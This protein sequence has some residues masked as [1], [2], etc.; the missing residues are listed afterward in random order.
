MFGPVVLGARLPASLDPNPRGG[1][2]GNPVPD[3]EPRGGTMSRIANV[4]PRPIL[5]A[6]LFLLPTACTT[7]QAVPAS[8]AAVI[9]EQRP[10][11]V[12]LTLGT[13]E[14]RSLL[15]PTVEGD[16]IFGEGEF[17]RVGV[18]I[19]DVES[20]EVQRFSTGRTI[21]SGAV[22]VLLYLAFKAFFDSDQFG[23]GTG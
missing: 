18:P 1:Q 15:A 19:T 4:L 8:P 5:V 14:R 3:R 6:A 21:V 7:W 12:R 11:E 22:G 23:R 16:S 20:V 9:S 10:D 17:G 2:G 13:S